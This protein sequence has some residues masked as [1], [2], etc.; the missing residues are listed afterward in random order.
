MFI[1]IIV[2]FGDGGDGGGDGCFV[3]VV[4]NVAFAGGG[5]S[6]GDDCY[7]IVVANVAFQHVLVIAKICQAYAKSLFSILLKENSFFA[8]LF[9][10]L[11]RNL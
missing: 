10:L 4:A 5:D 11:G 1:D 9:L 2:A 6:G 3:I 8:F 7:V